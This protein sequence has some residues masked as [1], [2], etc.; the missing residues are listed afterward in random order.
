MFSSKA[1]R[2]FSTF[3]MFSFELD[4]EED[5]VSDEFSEDS[6]ILVIDKVLELLGCSCLVL[7]KSLSISSI[8]STK[9]FSLLTLN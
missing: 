7:T 1:E 4:S 3:L 6:G 8:F 2:A 9:G 5:S